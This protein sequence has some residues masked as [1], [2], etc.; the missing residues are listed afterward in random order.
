[1]IQGIAWDDLVISVFTIT[2]PATGAEFIHTP[3]NH[4]VHPQGAFRED[5]EINFPVWYFLGATTC[6]SSYEGCGE[7]SRVGS[8]LTPKIADVHDGNHSPTSAP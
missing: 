7:Y 1:M 8:G 5:F 4:W 6:L 2:Q 3:Q